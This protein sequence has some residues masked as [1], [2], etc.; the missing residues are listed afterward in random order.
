MR[1][2][3]DA[4]ADHPVTPRDLAVHLG[5]S[6]AAVTSVLRRLAERGQILVSSHPDD[7]RSKIVRPSLRDLHTPA[8]ELSERV[9]ELEREFTPDE[10]AAI[11]R[12]VRRLT[13]EITDLL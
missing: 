5:V 3:A 8:D 9:E 2:I 12:F 13:E 1:L 6:T 10:V 7:A 11:S 4:P